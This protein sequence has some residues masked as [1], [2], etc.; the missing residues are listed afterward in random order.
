MGLLR[1]FRAG[2]NLTDY[3]HSQPHTAHFIQ[4]QSRV[5]KSATTATGN[6]AQKDGNWKNGQSPNIWM[7]LAMPCLTFGRTHQ[8]LV[9]IE[10]GESGLDDAMRREGLSACVEC[11]GV[12]VFAGW[13]FYIAR[14]RQNI[15]R[16][17]GI[18]GS[19]L[20]DFAASCLCPCAVVQEHERTVFEYC[21]ETSITTQPTPTL[22]MSLGD[23]N[24]RSSFITIPEAMFT[25]PHASEIASSPQHVHPLPLQVNNN[26]I[27]QLYESGQSSSDDEYITRAKADAA[28][29]IGN[30]G[31]D[32]TSRQPFIRPPMRRGHST[33]V[34]IST[35][36]EESSDDTIAVG[37]PSRDTWPNSHTSN[38]DKSQVPLRYIRTASLQR[39]PRFASV[40]SMRRPNSAS[41]GMM[42]DSR[43]IASEDLDLDH[44]QIIGRL[45]R[46]SPVNRD[47]EKAAR[48]NF[49][50]SQNYESSDRIDR[51]PQSAKRVALRLHNVRQRW[52]RHVRAI[53]EPKW[54]SNEMKEQGK[55][56]GERSSTEGNTG[57]RSRDSRSASHNI[58]CDVP[59]PH[60]ASLCSSDDSL[61]FSSARGSF[62]PGVT[63]DGGG[64]SVGSSSRMGRG[65]RST[66]SHSQSQSRSYDSSQRSINTRS[67]T[68]LDVQIQDFSFP[69]STTSR[70][71]TAPDMGTTVEDGSYLHEIRV[72]QFLAH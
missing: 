68:E 2:N 17:L 70:A 4:H 54:T 24:N 9:D 5:Q 51:E 11:F 22:P 37:I 62:A 30:F 23:G 41:E 31:T 56:K 59:V 1:G 28:A 35:I 43:R 14:E 3:L 72:A 34:S 66:S 27:C 13:G 58:P 65:F 16:R 61:E 19:G 32:D 7:E 26:L 69:T 44:M 71:H 6:T 20:T 36:E 48:R 42:C 29:I 52:H 64:S 21:V 50:D 15:R 38:L 25:S 60:K 47:C 18:P 45:R 49:L 40:G 55:R 12:S 53:S 8:R 57:P 63:Y 33:T 39:K 10:N 46:R 67:D